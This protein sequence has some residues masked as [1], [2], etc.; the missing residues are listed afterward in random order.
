MRTPLVEAQMHDRSE[1]SGRSFEEEAS[2]L[3][4]ENQ[5]NRTF[6]TPEQIGSLCLY[7]MSEAA[8]SATGM[9]V[10]IVGVWTA[11]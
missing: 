3:I 11:H 7:L 5:P 2:N 10:P 6:V 1:I 8:A 9:A 4:R